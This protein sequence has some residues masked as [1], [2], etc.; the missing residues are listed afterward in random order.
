[1]GPVRRRSARADWKVVNTPLGPV[2]L[3]L[4]EPELFGHVRELLSHLLRCALIH[5]VDDLGLE[6]GL[7]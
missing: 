5:E 1:M 7:V 2:E 4:L 3:D 6:H